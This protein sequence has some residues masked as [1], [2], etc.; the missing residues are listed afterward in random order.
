MPKFSIDYSKTHIYKIICK[1]LNMKDC[2]VRH[3]TNFLKRKQ[4]HKNLCHNPNNRLYKCYKYELIREN[5]GWDNRD[6]VL[7][8]TEACENG[9]GAVKREREYIETLNATLR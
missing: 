9:I 3:T 6:M 2:Y 7:I 4:H 5:G 1:Y 8:N